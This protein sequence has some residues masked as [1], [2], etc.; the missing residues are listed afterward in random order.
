LEPKSQILSLNSFRNLAE[1][2][3][4]ILDSVV[5]YASELLRISDVLV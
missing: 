3:I 5:V 1:R 2:L 4:A